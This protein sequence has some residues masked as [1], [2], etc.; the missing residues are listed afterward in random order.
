MKTEILQTVRGYVQAL[1][2]TPGR[3]D[4]AKVAII[5]DDGT[6]YHIAHKGAGMDLAD[7]ISADVEVRGI[8]SPL[9]AEDEDAPDEAGEAGKPRAF[10]LTARSYQLTDGFDDP[11]YDDA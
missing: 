9:P 6:E 3:E 11:W 1:P 2:K 5:V 4:A 10:L 7:F 8:V